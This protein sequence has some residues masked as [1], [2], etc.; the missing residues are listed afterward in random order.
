MLK[1]SSLE[2]RVKVDENK[3]I[4]L[5]RARNTKETA[6]EMGES[7]PCGKFGQDD[8]NSYVNGKM[9]FQDIESF[10]SH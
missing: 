6:I 7:S 1:L 2:S 5:P 8:Y 10:V 4:K 9:S 3:L